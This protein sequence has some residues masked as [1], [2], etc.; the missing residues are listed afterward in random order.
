M[1]QTLINQKLET[2]VNSRLTKD[3]LTT[4]LT[5]FFGGRVE[6]F[7][8]E[9]EEC[10][11]NELPSLDEQLIASVNNDEINLHIDIDLYYLLD[12]GGKY[13]ITETNFNYH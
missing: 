4:Q 1:N 6:V 12:N 9:R 2:L 7:E 8:Y 3:E 13:Y 10:V 5:N 11:K